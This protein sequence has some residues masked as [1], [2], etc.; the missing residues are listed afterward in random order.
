MGAE[1]KDGS[2]DGSN[3]F[4]SDR[5]SKTSSEEVDRHEIHIDTEVTSSTVA[6]TSESK[7]TCRCR[8][9]MP[10]SFSSLP[11]LEIVCTLSEF[12]LLSRAPISKCRPTTPKSNI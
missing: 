12:E 3:P 6:M 4:D 2:K 5:G 9:S 10:V 7:A 1:E 11:T 8:A